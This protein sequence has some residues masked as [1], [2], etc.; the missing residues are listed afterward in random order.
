MADQY[1]HK[2]AVKDV[3]YKK[4]SKQNPSVFVRSSPCQISPKATTSLSKWVQVLFAFESVSR[5][6]FPTEV[7]V[8]CSVL[9]LC[10]VD[11]HS[12]AVQGVNG[13][14][15]AFQQCWKECSFQQ[16]SRAGTRIGELDGLLW[17]HFAPSLP[18][19]HPI[20]D[21]LLVPML[22]KTMSYSS[23]G[24]WDKLHRCVYSSVVP[25]P[26]SVHPGLL[27]SS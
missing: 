4:Y 11:E 2:L 7:C 20:F 26:F 23:P 22:N 16:R 9:S 5:S 24:I 6:I 13:V 8:L 12:G 10:D 18:L 3:E 15:W 17:N 19:H 21:E 25:V 27:D 1:D 14:W